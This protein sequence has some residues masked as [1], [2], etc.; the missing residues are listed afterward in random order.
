M[1]TRSPAF[2]NVRANSGITFRPDADTVL[3]LPGQKD[4]FGSQWTD[5]SG[6]KNHGAITG[7]TWVQNS[8]GLWGLSFD[9]TDDVVLVTDDVSI[10]NIFD[11]G[12]T[13]I[14]WV[15]AL[16]D[17]EN[18]FGHIARKGIWILFVREELASAVK[19]VFSQVFSGD[20]GEWRTDARVLPLDI[21]T[22]VSL[23]YNADAPEN[24]PIVYINNTAITVGGGITEIA[25]PT[26]TRTSDATFD[27]LIGDDAGSTRSW[28][29]SLFLTREITSMLTASQIDGIYQ[30]E[31][32][33][34]G[35]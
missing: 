6:K 3:W 8:K 35:V 24:N 29:G 31:R 15:N 13:I 32:G 19:V 23:V 4:P 21:P 33:L 30:Q 12:G 9:G 5:E 27:L 1:V 22:M 16:S 7:A 18:T 28:D 14:T 11:G 34:F 10:Q 26:G 17:G 2:R 25:T 20:K